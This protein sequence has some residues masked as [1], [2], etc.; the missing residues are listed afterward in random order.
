MIPFYLGVG[1]RKLSL[2]PGE[3]PRIYSTLNGLSPER[4]REISGEMLS[5]RRTGEMERYLEMVHSDSGLR[6]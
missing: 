4:A 6:I 3:L 1:V 2:H 5:I